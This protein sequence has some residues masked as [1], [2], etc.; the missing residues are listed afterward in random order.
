[1][2]RPTVIAATIGNGKVIVAPAFDDQDLAVRKFCCGFIARA[3]IGNGTADSIPG[4]IDQDHCMPAESARRT[5][6]GM[7]DLVLPGGSASRAMWLW[8]AND[9]SMRFV[10]GRFSLPCPTAAGGAVADHSPTP[11]MRRILLGRRR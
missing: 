9:R 6:S 4:A 3:P 2:A 1:M 7:R 5:G 11:G 10:S 8:L